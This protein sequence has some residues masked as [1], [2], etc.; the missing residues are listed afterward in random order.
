MEDSKA[1]IKTCL[2]NEQAFCTAACPF[3]LD[4]RA[5][6]DKMQQ[7][8]Y[9]A[10]FRAF[11]N[12]VGFPGIVAHLCDEPCKAVCIRG[13][14]SGAVAG[15]GQAPQDGAVSI[16][17]L[18]R[19]ALDLATRK[20]PNNYNMPAKN[21]KIAVIGAGISGLACALR[22][23]SK[24]YAVTVYEKEDR[25]GGHLW[26]SL[27]SK[28][29]LK[30]IDHQFMHE[31]YTLRLNTRVT[32]LADLS[33]GVD[34]VYI[35]TGR[36]GETFGLEEDPGGA[37][38]TTAPGVFM[39]GQVKPGGCTSCEAMAHGLEAVH[40][41]ER[42]LKVGSMNAPCPERGTR[43]EISPGSF[44]PQPPVLPANGR[45]Y[46]KEEALAESRRCL[47][48][49]C[50][51]CQKACDLIYHSKKFPMKIAEDVQATIH[52]GTLAGNGTIAT[53]LI[54]TCSH[55]GLC[56]TVCPQD[57]DMGSFLLQSHRVMRAKGAMPWAF[58]EF[59]LRD[60]AFANGPDAGL[61]MLPKGYET[62]R[63]LFFPGC[64]LGGA[65]PAY[66]IESYTHLAAQNADTALMLHCCGAPADWAGET[67]LHKK[68]VAALKSIWHRL[69]EPEIIFACPTCRQMILRYLPQIQGTFLYPLLQG[70]GPKIK[71]EHRRLP[72]GQ[73][74][75]VSVFDPC[76]ARD[77]PELQQAVRDLVAGA[78]Y[79]REPLP[80]EGRHAQCC[81]W[82]GHISIA[83]P[84][85]SREMVHARIR[86]NDL[87]FVTYCINCRSVFASAGKPVFH[88]LDLIFDL[89]RADESPP[90]YTRRRENRAALKQQ[91]LQ[92]TKGS[93]RLFEIPYPK[94]DAPP[95]E[96]IMTPQ[97]S[98]VLHLPDQ[99]KEA[100][101]QKMILETDMEKV[102]A[103][104]ETHN[105]KIYDP[106]TGH[107]VGH[108]KIGHTT[109]WAAYKP[110]DSGFELA[111]G[112]S[113]RMSID[114]ED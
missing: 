9:N 58:H 65:D 76:S 22:L 49:A 50:Y 44:P 92:R 40:A 18:E 52:P 7:G 67:P 48:C 45:A 19:A 85:F 57:I 30:D 105:K 43:L 61:V 4:V 8:R 34:A 94:G 24:K 3:G 46:T 36:Q 56:K 59:W 104:C 102:V 81:S 88:I 68:V 95:K 54:A 15:A 1:R 109:F 35:A 110:L 42:Y 93:A 66:V 63:Y 14:T 38:A 84:E 113:H 75:T 47:K 73:S 71:T 12:A 39:G 64:Q 97:D 16:R 79:A 107:F 28:L 60:M 106:E 108:L 90:T 70:A 55:C 37:F 82:G 83:N 29:F 78:G 13:K 72:G 100:L 111:N 21:K 98:V 20:D 87:A 96:A 101:H 86:Q 77:E 74:D 103:H 41:I 2:Q 114:Q 26:D 10:A 69:G 11:S 23:C 17:L 25:I 80:M 89:H 62:V 6:M 91:V 27:P 51:A 31:S 32:A 5:F 33:P 99:V 112:Y 53:R